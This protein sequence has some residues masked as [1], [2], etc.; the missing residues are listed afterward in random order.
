MSKKKFNF[1]AHDWHPDEGHWNFDFAVYA[2]DE[3][4]AYWKARKVVERN[5][6]HYGHSNAD[7]SLLKDS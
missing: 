5:F 2:I 3:K 6:K 4:N 7:L 1:R